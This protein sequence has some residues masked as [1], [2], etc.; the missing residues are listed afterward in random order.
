MIYGGTIAKVICS[1]VV[2]LF[3]MMYILRIKALKR[4]I[5]S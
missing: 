5:I 3:A 4:E 2:L 1:V